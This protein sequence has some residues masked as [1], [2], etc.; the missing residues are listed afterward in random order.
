MAIC[1]SWCSNVLYFLIVVRKWLYY[2]VSRKR[3]ILS[4]QFWVLLYIFI[5]VCFHAFVSSTL[6]CGFFFLS[7]PHPSRLVHLTA[8]KRTRCETAEN[9][10]GTVRVVLMFPGF[11]AALTLDGLTAS[12]VFLRSGSWTSLWRAVQTLRWG[13]WWSRPCMKAALQINTV[14]SQVFVQVFIHE[15]PLRILMWPLNLHLWVEDKII[16]WKR[17][18]GSAR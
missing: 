4:T 10:K 1:H 2:S 7:I 11:L 8:D 14:S 12:V 9:Q 13:S 5:M 16:H 17:K 3:K 15:Q 18:K 6:L